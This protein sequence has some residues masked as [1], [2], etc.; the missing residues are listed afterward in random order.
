MEKLYTINDIAQITGITKRTLHYYDEIKLLKPDIILDNGYRQYNEQSLI[1]LQQILF[2]KTLDFPLKEIN[3]IMNN[4]NYDP[5]NAM[6]NQKNLL[7]LKKERLEGLINLI[8]QSLKGDETMNF[9]PFSLEEIKAHEEKYRNETKEKYG[10]SNNYKISKKKYDNYTDEELI[11]IQREYD[12]IF[13]GLALCRKESPNSENV[14]TLVKRWQDHITTYYYPC[15]KE[16]LL[17][18]SQMYALDDDFR[19]SMDVYG[20]GTTDIL[21]EGI[22]QYCE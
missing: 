2:F 14:Q 21:V 6:M 20:E 18:L 1:K 19:A 8:D 17:G 11:M 13:K 22:K 3:T 16:I 9:K 12:N 7:V 4:K 15:S 10:H 5:K